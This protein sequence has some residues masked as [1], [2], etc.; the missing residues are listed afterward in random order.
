MICSLPV[1][2]YAALR[3]WG[4]S[5]CGSRSYAGNASLRSARAGPEKPTT[6][7]KEMAVRGP[8][9]ALSASPFLCLSLAR[10]KAPPPLPS[11][12]KNDNYF[13]LWKKGLFPYLLGRR[14]THIHTQRQKCAHTHTHAGRQQCIGSVVWV[15]V[16]GTLVSL[17]GMCLCKL[18]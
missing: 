7:F 1:E 13:P 5:E 8:S 14:R 16:S 11:L 9:A 2:A 6:L 4:G 10:L 15:I 17:I 18:L 3:H 12:Y